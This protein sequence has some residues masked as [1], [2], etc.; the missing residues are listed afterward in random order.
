V[1]ARGRQRLALLIIK[2]AVGIDGPH[3][4]V[5]VVDDRPQQVLLPAV[6]QGPGVALADVADVQQMAA[7]VRLVLDLAGDRGGPARERDGVRAVAR[8]HGAPAGLRQDDGEVAADRGVA[9]DREDPGGAQVPP[10]DL[11]VAGHA[12]HGERA[13][14]QELQGG[15]DGHGGPRCWN[16]GPLSIS[17]L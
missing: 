14:V 2:S 7:V 8:E 3:D 9:V 16:I 5:E 12:D 17:A 10:A 15:V 13:G 1:Q 4:D 6:L 11:Q